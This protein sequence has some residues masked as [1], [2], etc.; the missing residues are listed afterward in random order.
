MR[1]TFTSNVVIIRVINNNRRK[2]WKR[3]AM[4]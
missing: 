3:T 1:I 2:D 4:R